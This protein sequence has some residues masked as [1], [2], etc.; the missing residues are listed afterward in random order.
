[1]REGWLGHLNDEARTFVVRHLGGA[2]L[3]LDRLERVGEAR[4]SVDGGAVDQM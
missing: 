4:A 2:G 3:G 1:L